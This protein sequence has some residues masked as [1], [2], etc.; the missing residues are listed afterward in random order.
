MTDA[1]ATNPK[2]AIASCKISFSLVPSSMKTYA[3]LA[4]TEG[5]VKYGAYNWR[6]AGIRA[7]VY[8][9]ALERHVESWWN[10]ED[11]DPK[12]GVPHLANALAC[13]GILIDAE[14]CGKM[15]DDRPPKADVGALIRSMEEK[16][17]H[18]KEIFADYDPHH[19]VIGDEI[20][21]EGGS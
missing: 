8:K 20:P 14:L 16:V 5:A 18:L 10:G 6:A 4:F 9:S 19:W 1:K 12:T 2:D 3:A 13:L 21:A 15:T 7:S 11:A 17:A